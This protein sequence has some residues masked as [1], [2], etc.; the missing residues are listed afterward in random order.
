MTSTLQLILNVSLGAIH[1]Q[2]ILR[3]VQIKIYLLRKINNC[4]KKFKWQKNKEDIAEKEKQLASFVDRNS[5]QKV[6]S[7]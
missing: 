6:D 2:Q 1:A 5:L 7:A 4:R 3:T